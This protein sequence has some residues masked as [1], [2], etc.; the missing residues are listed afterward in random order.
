MTSIEIQSNFEN[1]NWNSV[2]ELKINEQ[3]Q[4]EISS[5]KAEEYW[6]ILLILALIFIAI[7]ILLLK[8]W[9]S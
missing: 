4:I 8:L 9:K 3:G 2:S 6:R 1:S 7:E 5:L